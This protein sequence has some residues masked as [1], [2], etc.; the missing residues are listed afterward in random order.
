[1]RRYREH[2][3]DFSLKQNRQLATSSI[4][5][6]HCELDMAREGEGQEHC[7]MPGGSISIVLKAVQR[8]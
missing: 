5:A 7:V 8:L 6:E 3:G 4:L 1:V 2:R